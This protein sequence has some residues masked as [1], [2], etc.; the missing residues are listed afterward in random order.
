VKYPIVFSRELLSIESIEKL[1]RSI[2]LDPH[3][4]RQ[5]D[6]WSSDKQRL[7]IDSLLNGLMVPPLY[8]HA[9]NPES[10]YFVG[11]HRY[12]VVD[13]RQRLEALYA[14][15]DGSL[16]LSPENSILGDPNLDLE[17]MNMSALRE[18]LPWLYSAF[19]RMELET[20]I[21]DTSD[22][23]LIEELFSR[24]NE[25]VPLKA[26]EKRNR[27][28]VLAPRVRDAAK[29]W[30]FFA[31]RLPFG[32]KRYRHLDLIAKFMK[33][34]QH[35]LQGGR[36]PNLKKVELDRLFEQLRS[37]EADE[38]L[39]IEK[40]EN[41]LKAVESRL[42]RLS[43]IFESKDRLL[44]SIGMVTLYY[45]L[46]VQLELM[47]EQP[48]TRLEILKFEDDRNSIKGKDDDVLT[49]SERLLSNFGNYAQGPTSG[50][51]LLARMVIF[52]KVLRE[53]DLNGD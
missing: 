18:R 38:A 4:Q 9:L 11:Q 12:A 40:I 13:G 33:I 48:L 2:V 25:G 43:S 21:I 37:L 3:Y 6:V 34:E 28:Q 46:D 1:R 27:G 7:F 17:A 5:G 51:Y 14:F 15:L 29:D 22:V 50:S 53:I 42:D 19:M 44:G 23:D 35:A 49:P 8:W 31:D 16:S 26:A 24:L 20:I 52:L 30:Q 45:L 41:L 39:A 32:N 10:E 36:V 47:H